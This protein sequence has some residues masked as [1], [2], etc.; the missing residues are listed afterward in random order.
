MVKK[1]VEN[2]GSIK[3]CHSNKVKAQ[4]KPEVRISRRKQTMAACLCRHMK[5]VLFSDTTVTMAEKDRKSYWKKTRLLLGECGYAQNLALFYILYVRKKVNCTAESL[6]TKCAQQNACVTKTNSENR[7]GTGSGSP[8]PHHHHHHRTKKLSKCTSK[9]RL[10][11]S[12]ECASKLRLK[13]SAESV[14]RLQKSEP[15]VDEIL[16]KDLFATQNRRTIN[17]LEKEEETKDKIN[18]SKT[19]K[20]KSKVPLSLN[21]QME[22]NF[23]MVGGVVGE[24]VRRVDPGAS[25]FTLPA[26]TPAQQTQMHHNHHNHTHIT[27]FLVNKRPP[28]T[29]S[30]HIKISTAN[31]PRKSDAQGMREMLVRRGCK[32]KQT[33]GRSKAASAM[34]RAANAVRIEE[35]MHKL[36]HPRGRGRRKR[37]RVRRARRGGIE[38]ASSK[39]PHRDPCGNLTKAQ[40]SQHL[41]TGTNLNDT[42]H[43]EGFLPPTGRSW[44]RPG[45]YLGAAPLTPPPRGRRA[46][47]PAGP[48]LPNGDDTGDDD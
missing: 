47:R 26:P 21:E 44:T 12:A 39:M 30:K 38:R 46:G 32:I 34:R 36:G 41:K 13:D 35:Q 19:S 14:V 3:N 17:I 22:H 45:C 20:L 28:C 33:I 6:S 23:S 9:V 4:I 7:C 48:G 37:R 40:N 42:Q 25:R 31:S 11:D 24:P 43:S 18:T 16:T 29:V 10:M 5:D 8:S 2:F 27:S 1:H 15:T